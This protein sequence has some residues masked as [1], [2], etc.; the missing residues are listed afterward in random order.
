MK[1][2]AWAFSLLLLTLSLPAESNRAVLS[3]LNGLRSQAGGGQLLPDS[4]LDRTA[5]QYA[6]ELARRGV[7]SH[8]DG[9]GH[10]ALQRYRAQGGTT[11][12]VGEILGSGPDLYA[13]TAAW[14]QSA[15]HRDVVLKSQWTHCGVGSARFDGGEVLV[16]LFTAHRV[17]PLDIQESEAGFL[18]AGRLSTGQAAQPVLYSGTRLLETVEW[19]RISGEFAFEVPRSRGTLYHRLGYLEA[20]GRL[21]VTNTFFPQ[22]I[23]TSFREREYR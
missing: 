13:V 5:L 15:G 4:L 18:V 16:V 20:D 19:N 6:S 21:V 8:V 2:A 17:L 23:A 10:S 12:L 14:E 1:R 3:W 11:T 9:Q 22:N 7:L